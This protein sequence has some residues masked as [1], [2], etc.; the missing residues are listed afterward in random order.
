L[1]EA[2]SLIDEAIAADEF[3]TAVRVATVAVET[4]AKFDNSHITAVCTRRKDEV[5]NIGKEAKKLARHFDKLRKSANDPAANFEIGRFYCTVCGEWNAGLPLLEKGSNAA[6]KAAAKNDRAAAGEPDAQL[7]A[8]A[9][10]ADLAAGEKGPAKRA[11]ALRAADWYR[12]VLTK[13][14][15]DTRTKAVVA[16]GKLPICFLTDMDEVEVKAGPWPMGKRGD[17][18][19]GRAI[20]VNGFKYPLGIGLHPPD[21]GAAVVT[22]RLDGQYKTLATGVAI[23]DLNADFGGSISFVVVGD[24]KILWE[25]LPLTGRG[26][27]FSCE[28]SVKGVKTLQ[29]RTQA[30]GNAVSGHA[31]WLDPYVAK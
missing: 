16:M 6:W 25:S 10:W 1:T 4:A 20:E 12:K 19:V 3:T 31:V 18:G 24:D 17:V 23:N 9:K 11:L 30:E 29:L 26:T 28:T 21:D 8:G 13:G 5:T 22:Y 15:G 2:L 7:V 27:A 14:S